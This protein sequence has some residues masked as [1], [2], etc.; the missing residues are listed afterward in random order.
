[1]SRRQLWSGLVVSVLLGLAAALVPVLAL[2]TDRVTAVSPP[3]DRVQA[4]IDELRVDRVHVPPDGRDMLDEAAE[5]RLEGVVAGSDVPLYV[6]VWAPSDNAG[7]LSTDVVD[8]LGAAI[9]PRALFVVWEGPGRG[10]EG[11]LDGYLYAPLRFEGDPEARIRELVTELEGESVEPLDEGAGEGVVDVL[12]GALMGTLIGACAYGLLMM[13]VGLVRL[14][15]RR[16]FIV[17]G[18]WERDR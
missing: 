11:V 17:P 9:D 8:Q 10:H 1:M 3:G 7:Y 5:E 2:E 4:A 15:R 12:A 6:V 14:S 18:P 16:P 13:L